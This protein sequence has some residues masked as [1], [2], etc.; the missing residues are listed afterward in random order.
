MFNFIKYNTILV[1][2]FTVK[3]HNFK[4]Y[5]VCDELVFKFIVDMFLIPVL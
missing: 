1:M 3:L 4:T 5:F 2:Y